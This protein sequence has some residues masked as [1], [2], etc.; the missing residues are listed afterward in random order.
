MPAH[1]FAACVAIGSLPWSKRRGITGIALVFAS[2]RRN[3][4]KRAILP[5]N[6]P[7]T[8]GLVQ[9]NSLPPR[10]RP[11]SW[12]ET[13][14]TSSSEP[15]K[16]TLFQTAPSP[17]SREKPPG[18][19]AT[20]RAPITNATMDTGTWRRK[21][22]RQPMWSAIEPPKEAPAMAPKPKMPF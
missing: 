18:W 7:I 20:T 22:H 3:K 16:S 8:Q 15:E 14:T 10:L 11:T 12:T 6:E 9:G 13:A 19:L 5:A 4:A 17:L 21:H 1:T 2:T